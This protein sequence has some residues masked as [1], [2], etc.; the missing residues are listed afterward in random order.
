[1][2][3]GS[4]LRVCPVVEGEFW[5]QSRRGLYSLCSFAMSLYLYESQRE[6]PFAAEPGI[7]HPFS[8]RWCPFDPSDSSHAPL[9]K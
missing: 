4:F 3:S 8:L 9:Q 7:N 6:R 2:A 1:M 5:R